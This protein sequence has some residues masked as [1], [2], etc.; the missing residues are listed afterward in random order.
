MRR[1]LAMAHSYYMLL[2]LIQ[3]RVTEYK[4]D[5]MEIIFT[6]A[7][8][9]SAQI[10][11]RLKSSYIFDKCYYLK[12]SSLNGGD[13]INR[14]LKAA[15]KSIFNPKRLLDDIEL[16]INNKNYDLF[17]SY[18]SCR[19]EEQV[20]FSALKTNNENL[21]CVLF[22]EG[23][24]S[25]YNPRGIFFNKIITNS[26]LCYLKILKI[27][28]KEK[29]VLE[30]NITAIWCF[31]PQLLQYQAKFEIYKI[32]PF[33]CNNTELINKINMI[34]DYNTMECSI[35]EPI[36]FLEDSAIADGHNSDDIEFVEKLVKTCEKGTVAVK[37]HPRSRTNRFEMLDVKT[38]T[39]AFPL[40]L[41]M[42]NEQKP[43][44]FITMN[45][46]APL[47]CLIDFE[48]NNKAI[49]LYKCSKYRADIVVNENFEKHINNITR[50]Y[51]KNKLIVPNNMNEF[52]DI[53]K[54]YMLNENKER[55]G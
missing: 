28:G 3:L 32:P 14:K 15:I 36:I 27:C 19:Y 38:Y 48:T 16:K 30:N 46:G 54:G 8:S 29:L 45:S 1:I 43:K 31:N 34:F 51:G 12:N 53:V 11:E 13:N 23:M 4:N 52:M 55:G 20:I 40:E 41:F 17:M 37:L 42:I 50:I 18:V 22:E 6:D 9:D 49:M 21:K 24:V 33:N 44:I 10:F 25:Y 5:Y 39:K 7:S 26:N 2:V 47:S 35:S